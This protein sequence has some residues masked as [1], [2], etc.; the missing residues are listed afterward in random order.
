M[1]L[2]IFGVLKQ[3][4]AFLLYKEILQYKQILLATLW[5]YLEKKCSNLLGFSLDL[6]KTLKVSFEG[7]FLEI[8]WYLVNFRVQGLN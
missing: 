2:L 8:G 7:G 6:K 1:T 5:F 4:G 3:C